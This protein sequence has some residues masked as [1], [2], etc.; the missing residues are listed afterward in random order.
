MRAAD[1]HGDQRQVREAEDRRRAR[2]LT[3]SSRVPQ[4]LKHPL[5]RARQ[6]GA[7]RR[8]T[9][10]SS[11]EEGQGQDARRSTQKV[12][13]KGNKRTV[14]ATFIT[15]ATA[16]QPTQKFT[17]TKTAEVLVS[18]QRGSSSRGG[19]R[20]APSGLAGGATRVRSARLGETQ[21]STAAAASRTGTRDRHRHER[22][23]EQLVP[24]ARCGSRSSTPRAA[25]TGRPARAARA[26][27]R[28]QQQSGAGA[29]LR[30]D[31]GGACRRSRRPAW[32]SEKSVAQTTKPI[33][34]GP[35]FSC[36]QLESPL[37]CDG[38]ER[39]RA[40]GDEPGHAGHRV[41]RQHERVAEQHVPVVPDRGRVVV[42]RG[43]GRGSRSG[44]VSFATA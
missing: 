42:A 26:A 2:R 6:L 37:R 24:L 19:L 18:V 3:S 28:E 4:N 14:R 1:R 41:Q 40:A 35:A 5:V 34:S 29:E 17:A 10:S 38:R 15:E 22:G 30:G 32:Q 39:Q 13:C 43:S 27:Q 25:G 31:R 8:T 23:R 44:G 7:P 16:T 9:R 33:A 11:Q 20:A 36:T 12:G 21:T